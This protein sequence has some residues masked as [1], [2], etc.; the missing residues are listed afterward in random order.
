MFTRFRLIT[1]ITLA[2]GAIAD[3][4]ADS[5]LE[6]LVIDTPNRAGKPQPVIIKDGRVMVKGAGG[7]HQLDML[8]R[9][10][11]DT[12]FIIDHGKRS[13]MTLDPQQI[14]QIGQ[15]AEQ[16]QPLLQGFGEQL[17][18]LSPQQRAK[19]QQMLGDSVSIDDIAAAAK[20]VESASIVKTGVGKNIAGIACEEMN[21]V[22]GATKTAEFC[23]ADPSRLSLSGDD[24][25]TVRSLLRFS[26][27]LAARTQGMANQFG[28]K[29]PNIRI[30][31]LVGVPVEMKDYSSRSQSAVS[32]NRIDTA[33]VAA[34]VMQIPNGYRPTPLTLWK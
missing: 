18:R 30:H 16:L 2:I 29:I 34:E 8:Y 9:R 12:L 11:Q 26:E 22:Q 10:D 5:T 21:V 3:V 23:L 24:Y 1:L 28:F 31:D 27:N 17:G 15:Q 33:A 4:S 25:D 19:W 20:P 13:Y 7:D 6:Y 14:S 32:L